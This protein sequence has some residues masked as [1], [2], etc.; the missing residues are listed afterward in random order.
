MYRKG[1]NPPRVCGRFK[2][3]DGRS[4][5][6]RN[7]ADVIAVKRDDWQVIVA[8]CR[9]HSTDDDET[10]HRVTPNSVEAVQEL[11]IALAVVERMVGVAI[12]RDI[13]EWE[14][15]QSDE[16]REAFNDMDLVE[17]LALEAGGPYPE[18]ESD[19]PA[20]SGTQERLRASLESI[21]SSRNLGL[22]E[23]SGRKVRGS[24][25]DICKDDSVRG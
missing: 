17:R 8:K 2:G 18:E 11:L 12:D 4:M 16:Y 22:G 10:W 24:D 23:R 21:T 13:D 7:K 25:G 5:F 3:P 20:L 1:V 9:D 15:R 6:C 14:L 19:L